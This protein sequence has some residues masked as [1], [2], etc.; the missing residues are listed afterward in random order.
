MDELETAE[1]IRQPGLLFGWSRL[2]VA[3][4]A[5]LLVA[6]LFGL[7]AASEFAMMHEYGNDAQMAI[8]VMFAVVKLGLWLLGGALAVGLLVVLW[9]RRVWAIVGLV[10]LLVWAVAIGR[11]SW[12]FNEGRRALADAASP[13]TSPERLHQLVHFDGI[14]AGYELDNRLATNRDTPPDALRE[15]STR[16]EQD[17]TQMLLSKNPR[18]PDDV[19]VRL[20]RA[21]K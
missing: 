11:A 12:Q 16:V 9:P 14:Q 21:P 20:R 19:L 2:R 6:L 5:I 4:L 8:W 10:V 17:G 18:T 1:T 7:R 3:T 13:T 15:L